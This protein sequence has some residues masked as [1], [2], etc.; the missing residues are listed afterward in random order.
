MSPPRNFTLRLRSQLAR[1]AALAAP[2][3]RP[4]GVFL[5]PPPVSG[6]QAFVNKVHRLA[7][8]RRR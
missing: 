1:S 3:A 5:L 6:F 8:P 4:E 7:G 2:L